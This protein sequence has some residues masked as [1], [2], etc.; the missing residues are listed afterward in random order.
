MEKT[1]WHQLW[2]K[3]AIAFHAS[4][5]H[6][7]L[8]KHAPSLGLKKDSRVFLP[9][10]GKSLDISWF[11]S[12]GCRVVGAELSQLAIEQLFQ[13]LSL[14]PTI[15]TVGKFQCYQAGPIDIFVGDFFEVT[16]E[17]LGPVDM[18]Y[19]RAALVALPDSMRS[20][21]TQHLRKITRN[22]S[23]LLI[24]YEYD[25]TILPGPPFAISH[26]EVNRHYQEAYRIT[27]L[28]SMDVPGGLKGKCTARESGYLLRCA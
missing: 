11:L 17:M 15:S 22:A 18:V 10:C 20:A 24:T 6:L 19:D 5:P 28:E 1:F 13:E 8:V 16:E 23:Q 12:Q 2:E 26:D 7:M 14:K 9:L 25:Q 3:N 4:Q 21:Y 27:L